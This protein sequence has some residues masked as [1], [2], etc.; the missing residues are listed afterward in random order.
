MYTKIIKIN[1]K[2]SA[3]CEGLL[4]PECIDTGIKIDKDIIINEV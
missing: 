1:E 3:F 2:D 4:L